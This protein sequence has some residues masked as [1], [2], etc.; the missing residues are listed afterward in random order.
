MMLL[1]LLAVID[2]H[3]DHDVFSDSITMTTMKP[4]TDLMIISLTTFPSS[5]SPYVESTFSYK[6]LGEKKELCLQQ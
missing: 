4:P 2:A 5:D 6:K 3:K 1:L